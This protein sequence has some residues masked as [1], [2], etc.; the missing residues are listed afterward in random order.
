MRAKYS[1]VPF[2][3]SLEYLSGK[4]LLLF[5]CSKSLWVTTLFTCIVFTT[6]VLYG[7][8]KMAAYLALEVVRNRC[9]QGRRRRMCSLMSKYPEDASANNTKDNAIGHWRTWCIESNVLNLTGNSSFFYLINKT[10]C[11]LQSI[12]KLAIVTLKQLTKLSITHTVNLD[13]WLDGQGFVMQ[14]HWS[15]IIWL[16]IPLNAT[17]DNN[18]TTLLDYTAN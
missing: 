13:R 6:I 18:S 12:T 8:G 14:V 15:R 5:L 17:T 4:D 10:V 9:L 11:L 7:F 1:S 2:S 16:W 3:L